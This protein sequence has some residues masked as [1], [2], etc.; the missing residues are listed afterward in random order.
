MF[1][2]IVRLQFGDVSGQGEFVGPAHQ[3]VA[4]HFLRPQRWFAAGSE[5]DPQT[6][7]DRAN[8]SKSLL[9]SPA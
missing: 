7:D 5:T 1:R 9:R 3:L 4:D 6:G 2:G 8:A